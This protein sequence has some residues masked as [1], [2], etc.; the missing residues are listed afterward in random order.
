[1]GRLSRAQLQARNRARVLAAA[2]QEFAAHGFRG[3][4]ID[5]IAD[6]AG[7]TRGAVY[8]NFPGKRAL[9]F[10]VLADLAEHAAPPAGPQAAGDAREALG[11]LARAWL[12]R[13]PLTGEPESARLTRDLHPEI[14]AEERIRRPYA[15]LLKLDAVLL[16]LALERLEGFP[17]RRVKV[18]ESVLAALHGARQLSA[19][20]PGFVEP[21]GVVS[22]CERLAGLDLGDWWPVLP[23]IP[24]V[25]AVDEG[26][27]EPY[28]HDLVRGEQTRLDGDGVVAVLGLNRLEAAEEAV[29][30]GSAVTAILVTSDP[31][32]LAPLARLV[33]AEL[34][35]CLREAFP[36]AAW[37]QVRVVVDG[38]GLAAV[39]GVAAGDD[40]EVALR[41]RGGRVV[42]RA[43]GRGACHV[44]ASA[45]AQDVREVTR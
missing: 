23:W 10:A 35:G 15:Q 11:A 20:A 21:F 33:V 27:A 29:R 2:R 13:L 44:A 40:T 7:F 30:A 28:G 14:L 9:Y 42:L 22:V 39:A 18:A 37:P 8:S 34:T 17:G 25:R 19:A 24:R 26:W 16:G 6:R 12:A 32:E 4:R 31:D 41:I 38:G 43:E 36:V 5:T 45:G 3:A 1:M